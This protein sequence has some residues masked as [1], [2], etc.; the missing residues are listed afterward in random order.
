M[1][2]RGGRPVVSSALAMVAAGRGEVDSSVAK[3]ARGLSPSVFEKLQLESIRHQ[4]D[5]AHSRRH[6]PRPRSEATSLS[7]AF[8]K[9]RT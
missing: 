7:H 5:A 1:A 4:L 3:L 8:R 6:V 2:G 9:G